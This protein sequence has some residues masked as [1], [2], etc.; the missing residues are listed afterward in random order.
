MFAVVKAYRVCILAV[1][2]VLSCSNGLILQTYPLFSALR[3][4]LRLNV[5]YLLPD[6]VRS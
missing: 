5:L 6:K 1:T 2:D 4:Y 3:E